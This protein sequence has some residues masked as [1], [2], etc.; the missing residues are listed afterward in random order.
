MEG[1]IRVEEEKTPVMTSAGE[2]RFSALWFFDIGALVLALIGGLLTFL[3]GLAHE[4]NVF[5]VTLV[6]DMVRESIVF[7]LIFAIC[8]YVIALLV[9]RWADRVSRSASYGTGVSDAAL[10][11]DI[12][13]KI[14]H[15]AG[16][17]LYRCEPMT[18]TASMRRLMLPFWG[19]AFLCW[20]PWLIIYWP[21][22]MRDDTIAQLL[23]SSG[24]HGYYTQHP[25]FDTF[26]FD[27]FWRI[28]EVLGDLRYGLGA[29]S[30]FQALALSLVVALVL[31]YLRKIGTPWLFIIISL[32]FFSTSYIVVG[33]V[34][35]MGKDS[36]HAV[37]MAPLALL[38]IEGCRTRG[39]VFRRKPV[40]ALFMILIAL[41]I[42]TKRTGLAV[43]IC[44]ALFLIIIA[45]GNRL[46]V[47]ISTLV[48]VLLVQ[49]VWNPI[50]VRFT[51]AE[52]SPGKEVY[53]LIT[54]PIGRVQAKNPAGITEHERELLSGFMDVEAAGDL[55]N[56]WRTDETVWSYKDDATLGDK[57]DA[58]KAW[59]SIGLRN[60]KEYV[61]AYVGFTYGWFYVRQA[62]SYP[63][64]SQYLF[65]DGYMEQWHGYNEDP[66]K[67][68]DILN[69]LREPMDRP[70]WV[71]DVAKGLREQGQQRYGDPLK[72]MALYVTY[73]P[74]AIGLYLLTRRRWRGLAAW[75]FLGF[76]VVSLYLSPLAL[77]WY[78]VAVYFMLPAFN[79][80]IFIPEPRNDEAEQQAERAG[81]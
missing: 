46:K 29:Y 65:T 42:M 37:F 66:R 50:S 41:S 62:F 60:I 38:F 70:Q 7:A 35:T 17:L 72:S 49:C 67:I 23:Q 36:L 74:L 8:L 45:K 81:I 75:T 1:G 13:E 39:A 56:P 19:I 21:G 47:F 14:R 54:Q 12:T 16:T 80:L 11:A 9:F 18:F 63:G 5:E 61:K 33:V 6:P 78:P 40:L 59:C 28:G 69:S 24:L 20:S 77:F 3:G 25:L 2:K 71:N 15:F 58:V 4:T 10:D 73:I 32:V 55:Y 53:G 26:F 31:C 27:I 44:G 48:A 30:I 64:D 34:P 68:D 79:G 51:G 57:I 22:S 76:D 52:E 43:I